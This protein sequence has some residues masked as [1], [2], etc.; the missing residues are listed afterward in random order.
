MGMYAGI[1]IIGVDVPTPR[2]VRHKPAGLPTVMAHGSLLRIAGDRGH[3]AA[4]KVMLLGVLPA[5]NCHSFGSLE[6]KHKSSRLTS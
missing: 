4:G 5:P 6:R 3:F 2:E 1:G